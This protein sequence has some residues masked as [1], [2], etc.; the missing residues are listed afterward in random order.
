MI[1]IASGGLNPSCNL[2]T[3]GT[4]F[5]NYAGRNDVDAQLDKTEN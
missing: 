3:A 2:S 4:P 1:T 5:P